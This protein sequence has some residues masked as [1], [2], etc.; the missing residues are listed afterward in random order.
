MSSTTIF[1]SRYNLRNDLDA[2]SN[3][4]FQNIVAGD[5]VVL[6]Q[7]PLATYGYVAQI[8][9]TADV[10]VTGETVR[11][12]GPIHTP[13]KKVTIC[14]RVIETEPDSHGNAAAIIVDGARGHDGDSLPRPKAR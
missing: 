6:T 2:Q 4:V 3:V 9:P 12:R 8:A 7:D 11:I 13:G 14:A 10:V 1:D 5:L